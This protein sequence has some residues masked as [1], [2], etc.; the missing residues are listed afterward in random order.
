[1]FVLDS[2]IL[3]GFLNGDEKIR[4]WMTSAEKKINILLFPLLAK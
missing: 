3:I 2:N 1:M 4:I